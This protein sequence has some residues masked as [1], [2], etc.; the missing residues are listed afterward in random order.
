MGK[1]GLVQK[2]EEEFQ[3]SGDTEGEVMDSIIVP[4]VRDRPCRQHTYNKHEHGPVHRAEVGHEGRGRG[5]HGGEVGGEAEEGGGGV[6]GCPDA[7][8]TDTSKSRTRSTRRTQC[9]PRR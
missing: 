6:S 2:Q 4:Q 9:K 3:A 1:Q 7:S 8:Y 5:Q